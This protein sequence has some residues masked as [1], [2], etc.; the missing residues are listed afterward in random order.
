[1]AAELKA[2][3]VELGGVDL[4]ISGDIPIG[5]GLSSSASLELVVAKALMASAGYDLDTESLARVC[6][7]A[8]IRF[9]G[10][11]CGIMDQ[12]SIAAG[13]A[14]MAMLL[15]CQSLD[16]QF[17]TI[18]DGI[19]FVVIDSGAKHQ[20]PDSGYNDRADECRQAI[21]ILGNKDIPSLRFA[22]ID[23]IQQ[24]RAQLGDTLHRR[25]RHVVTENLR[26]LDAFAALEASDVDKLGAL[27]N[28]SHHSLR[29]DYEV[30]CEPIEMLISIVNQIPVCSRRT[31]GSG[32]VLAAAY[33]PSLIPESAE[34]V[35]ETASGS[36]GA[37][38]GGT[39]W[40]HIVE[41]ADAATEIHFE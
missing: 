15:D 37:L 3:D 33:W 10:V 35:I 13:R 28:E 40:T 27:L 23:H 34:N 29:D 16:T 32:A 31:N 22:S 36:Y 11:D 2:I 18:P 4:S 12:Y 30:S 20:L 7:Q 6:R 25:C 14:G 21:G 26:T 8:E 19:A 41:S 38:I 24:A 39:P 17:A 9:A 1:M 5:S